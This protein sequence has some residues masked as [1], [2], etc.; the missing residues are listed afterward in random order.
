M[1]VAPSVRERKRELRR[2]LRER[3]RALGD[4][5]RRELSARIAAHVLALPV[6]REARV[7]MMYLSVT[8]EEP[9]TAAL[10]QAALAAGKRLCVPRFGRMA[11]TMEPVMIDSLESL[12]AGDS[13]LPIPQPPPGAGEVCDPAR[14]DLNLLPCVSADAWGTRLGLGGGH[15]DRLLV[16]M[17]PDAVN[18]GLLF[19]CQLV[20]T[21]P[22]EPHDQRLSG[23]VTEEGVVWSR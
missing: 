20:E 23:F 14:I 10:A 15:F 19:A 5:M 6:W 21:L 17:R 11:A 12:A 2:L 9:G 13:A 1:A 7:V 3:R 18:L 22:R 4:E 8:E 16:S